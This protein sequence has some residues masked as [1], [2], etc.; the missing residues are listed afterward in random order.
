MKKFYIILIVTFLLTSCSNNEVEVAVEKLESDNSLL[1]EQIKSLEKENQL[2][3]NQN[4]ELVEKNKSLNEGIKKKDSKIDTLKKEI[5]TFQQHQS[6]SDNI[7]KT[8]VLDAD[9][10]ND[11]EREIIKLESSQNKYYRLFT[12]D[13][14]IT[15][16][17]LN[18]DYDFKVVDI[19]IEDHVKEIAI[20]EW[21]SN[22][23]E[24]KTKFYIYSTDNI[25]YIGK[26]HGHINDI[27]I[28]G[29]GSLIIPAKG[30]ILYSWSYSK[31]YKLST[32]HMLVEEPQE[33][34]QINQKVKVL[35][36]IP[37]LK[38]TTENEMIAALT[39]GE[40]VTLLSSDNK[41]WCQVEKANG[42][43]GWFEVEDF[44]KIKGTEYTAKDV[45]EGL[46]NNS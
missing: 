20:S 27:T 28:N 26:I 21:G 40:E 31:K 44:D 19:D 30:N 2:L 29:D 33:L 3:N 25:Y 39:V 16:I 1:K 10:N 13:I 36:S 46:D 42:V 6:F 35:K 9:L 8:K 41:K 18:V 7:K 4:K 24:P 45:F 11:G 17:G 23:K 12:N 14:S 32:G 5:E 38:S 22:S 43:K 15:S 34:Y 37:L